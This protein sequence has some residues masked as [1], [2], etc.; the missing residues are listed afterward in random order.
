MTTL[1][2]A[3]FVEIR[4]N[5]SDFQLLNDEDLNKQIFHHP[6]GLRLSLNGFVIIRK[7]FTAY[8]FELPI[9]IKSRH[10]RNLS[11]LTYPYFFS[12]KRLILFSSADA[13]MVKLCG[14]IEIFLEDH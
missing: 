11:K 6:A 2:E 9:T 12:H 14:S 8:S 13:I 7:I 10:Q 1:K 5:V 4:K 3:I